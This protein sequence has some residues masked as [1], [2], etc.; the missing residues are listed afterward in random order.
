MEEGIGILPEAAVH[1]QPAPHRCQHVRV[2]Q[3]V[4]G[5]LAVAADSRKG[6]SGHRNQRL[7]HRGQV[8][9]GRQRQHIAE[10]SAAVGHGVA[11]ARVQVIC[12]A[13]QRGGVAVAVIIR[14]IDPHGVV[15]LPQCAEE[16]RLPVGSGKVLLRA[17]GEVIA[18]PGD[19]GGHA[20]VCAGVQR[21]II[22]IGGKAGQEGEHVRIL[23]QQLV[24]VQG[25]EPIQHENHDVFARRN[26]IQPGVGQVQL[27]RLSVC[28]T[29]SGL[30]PGVVRASGRCF[31]AC[32]PALRRLRAAR[33]GLCRGLRPGREQ[34]GDKRDTADQL[35]SAY[36][37]QQ[38][39]CH[40]TDHLFFLHFQRSNHASDSCGDPQ[41][42]I[43]HDKPC[44]GCLRASVILQQG[45]HSVVEEHSL[46][47]AHDAEP[48][49]KSE[50]DR[51]YPL[52]QQYQD[53]RQQHPHAEHTQRR[54][55]RE[56]A[57]GEQE[58]APVSDPYIQRACEAVRECYREGA[59][60]GRKKALQVRSH[61]HTILPHNINIVSDTEPP[62]LYHTREVKSRDFIHCKIF[63]RFPFVGQG[64]F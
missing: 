34:L 50:G 35:H 52:R 43:Q 17:P 39:H 46:H 18:H 29:R 38:D 25:V 58:L 47:A 16:V 14:R 41:D 19:H 6:R 59:E 4:C 56:I 55:S 36:R 51:V 8:A 24:I 12:H 10:Q 27:I 49:E 21:D 64:V 20:G 44:G 61:L 33:A 28:C 23:R 62:L 13:S 5:C 57:G 31:R 40:G 45:A 32:R 15:I 9:V 37:D 42:R 60:K 7:Q 1:G 53:C 3:L 48:R 54:S 2:I 30:C 11:V 63:L 22:R 26:G